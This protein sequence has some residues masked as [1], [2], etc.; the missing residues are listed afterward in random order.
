MGF[1]AGELETARRLNLPIVFIV[2]NNSG[3]DWIKTLQWLHRQR[4]FFGVDFTPVDYSRVG[5]AFGCRGVRV[6]SPH[7]LTEALKKSLRSDE[8]WVIDI[9]IKPMYQ[10]LPPVASWEEMKGERE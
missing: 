8:P 5:E 7:Q 2:F 9:P 4:E 3:F 1:S 10:E 6:N